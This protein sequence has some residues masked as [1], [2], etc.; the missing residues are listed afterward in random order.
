M[1]CR[2]RDAAEPAGRVDRARSPGAC[3]TRRA[4]GGHR[5]SGRVHRGAPR[6]GAGDAP[7]R[8]GAFV[9]HGPAGRRRG[10]IGARQHPT[11]R[12]DRDAERFARAR[13]PGERRPAIDRQRRGPRTG[14]R[15][16]R[17]ERPPGAV[18]RDAHPGRAG[19]GDERLAFVDAR[20]R[21]M[22]FGRGHVARAERVAGSIHGD[23][24]GFRGARDRA[25]LAR[26]ID[27]ARRPAER[28]S[29]AGPCRCEAAY[30]E[31]QKREQHARGCQGPSSPERS[32]RRARGALAIASFRPSGQRE[33]PEVA[34]CAWW[35]ATRC[36]HS[37]CARRS[38]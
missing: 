36:K 11:G 29:G 4:A 3:P 27:R 21:P 16:G 24:E 33:A 23:A 20:H 15:A 2:A 38:G 5:A 37:S 12:I 28:G 9:L 6:R 13:D 1:R 22:G 18:D 34:A 19:D 14:E 26:G 31:Q 8:R 10:R 7:Q 35:V 25:R 17:G 30:G 32:R